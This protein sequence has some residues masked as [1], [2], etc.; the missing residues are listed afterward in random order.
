MMSRE[1]KH[2][3]RLLL[4]PKL[5]YRNCSSNNYI[6]RV[7]FLRSLTMNLL[8][9]YLLCT[10]GRSPYSLTAVTFPRLVLK[11]KTQYDSIYIVHETDTETERET[12][13]QTFLRNNDT[14]PPYYL[15]PFQSAHPTHLT[16]CSPTIYS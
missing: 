11:V 6:V 10:V 1:N 4:T 9:I 3:S 7:W 15:F 13:K 14:S 5:R 12:N 2:L 16:L 8:F